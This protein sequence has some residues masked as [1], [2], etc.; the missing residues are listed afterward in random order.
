MRYLLPI[1]VDLLAETRGLRRIVTEFL[2]V[3]VRLHPRGALMFC[4]G[5]LFKCATFPWR[6][7]VDLVRGD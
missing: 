1:E 2:R 7:R 6:D 3:V 4:L 5:T